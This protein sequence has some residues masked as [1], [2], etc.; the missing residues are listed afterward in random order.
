MGGQ[1]THRVIIGDG[2]IAALFAEFA[3]LPA[4]D[5]LTVIGPKVAALGRGLAYEETAKDLPWRDAYL[6][7][8][9]SEGVDP[10]FGLWLSQHWTDLRDRM[11]GR[12]PDW[13]RAGAEL[14]QRDDIGRLN[15]PRAVFG[16][17]IS[18]RVSAA[19]D[20][21]RNAGA[22]ITLIEDRVRD[23]QIRDGGFELET[24]RSGPLRA[25]AVDIATG[26]PLTQRIDGDD[27]RNAAPVLF[28]NE[29]EI[30]ERVRMGQ[31]IFCIGTGATMLDVLR[32]CQSVAGES[33]HLTACAPSGT[34]PE[35][36][37]PSFPRRDLPLT[38]AGPYPTAEAFLDAVRHDVRQARA[39]G[40]GMGDLRG[41]FRTLFIER[42]LTGFLPDP[43]EARQIVP[44]MARWLLGGTRDT[45][46]DFHRLAKT[47]VTQVLPGKVRAIADRPAGA[48]VVIDKDGTEIRYKTG[49]VVNC[50]GPGSAPVYDPLTAK[51][52]ARGWLRHC[53]VSQGLEVGAGLRCFTG[54]A[55]PLRHLSPATTVIGEEAIGSPLYDALYLRRIVERVIPS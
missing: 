20:R 10:D 53:G 45:V 7:N 5:R 37:I 52:L 4:G 55:A 30:A 11:Q 19:L 23:V 40:M 44:I 9:P 24:Q 25:D 3:P 43:N 14:I 18:I 33:F 17:F 39:K 46:Q 16:D 47:G 41:G 29:M 15:A 31:P 27:G 22:H 51:L 13:L 49:F 36:L 50:S 48:T 54:A 26:G 2:L 8:S 12:Q 28:G 38:L 42:G 21:H 34:V 35:A 6:L 32:L 1:Q